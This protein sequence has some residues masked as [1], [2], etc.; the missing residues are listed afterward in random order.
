MQYFLLQ[1]QCP[2]RR[3]QEFINRE[4]CI[5]DSMDAKVANDQVC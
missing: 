2:I 4:R 5:V 3:D 1:L